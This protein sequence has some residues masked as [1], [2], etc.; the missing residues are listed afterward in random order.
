[1]DFMQ[2]AMCGNEWEKVAGNYIHNFLQGMAAETCFPC[3]NSGNS[4]I[5][6]CKYQVSQPT[7]VIPLLSYRFYHY[8]SED[9]SSGE[10]PDGKSHEVEIGV[11]TENDSDQ[12]GLEFSYRRKVTDASQLGS[13]LINM[14]F[15]KPTG[16]DTPCTTPLSYWVLGVYENQCIPNLD[17]DEDGNT[18][19]FSLTITCDAN[20]VTGVLY[21]DSTTCQ[22][23]SN[24]TSLTLGE[25]K[26]TSDDDAWVMWDDE[27]DYNTIA[28][29]SSVSYCYSLETKDDGDKEPNSL[30][31]GAI[32]GIS[33]GSIALVGCVGVA[34]FYWFFVMKRHMKKGMASQEV[35]TSSMPTTNPVGPSAPSSDKIPASSTDL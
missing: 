25:C 29:H 33:L 23:E 32:V 34:F 11:C 10:T 27:Q 21:E 5:K 4:Q 12:F 18:D 7:E 8:T 35:E 6:G 31:T 14:E 1:M 16:S 17:P 19:N 26:L 24:S 28:A 13:G 30:S 9:C 22:G 3:T 2:V 15:Q 20:S